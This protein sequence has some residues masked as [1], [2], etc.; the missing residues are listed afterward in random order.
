MNSSNNIQ[1][2]VND[3]IKMI[4]NTVEKKDKYLGAYNSSLLPSVTHQKV[5]YTCA[6][7]GEQ[8]PM[9]LPICNQS[10]ATKLFIYP[11]N[12]NT[13]KVFT[14]CP[15][16]VREILGNVS[17]PKDDSIVEYRST[18]KFA[19]FYSTQRVR[20]QAD[21]AAKARMSVLASHGA[22]LHHQRH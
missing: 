10:D 22:S 17:Q 14:Q 19:N 6:A 1:T 21:S 13:D 20:R 11:E 18:R 15:R 7:K 4:T 8:T 9:K 2:S 3:R 16:I 5:R 12:A